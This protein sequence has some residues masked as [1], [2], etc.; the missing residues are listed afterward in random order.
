MNCSTCQC[1]VGFEVL[2]MVVMNIFWDITPCSPLPPA[3]ALISCL[4]YSS[5]LK[6]EAICSFE[7]LA[8]FNGLHGVIYQ[9]TV[10]LKNAVFW[11]VAPCRSCVK[12][13]FS[14]TS[15]HTRST[16]R[17]IPED[18]ILHSHRHENLKS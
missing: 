11:A 4:S 3:F 6:M 17:H 9:K 13:R 12:R 15:V 14:E 16:Q 18:G 8:D 10:I 1:C 2:R 7:T 5:T